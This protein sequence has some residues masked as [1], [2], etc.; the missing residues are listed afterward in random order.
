MKYVVFKFIGVEIPIIFP[1]D[2]LNHDNVKVLSDKFGNGKPV[3]AGKCDISSN[4]VRVWGDSFSLGIKSRK[5]DA[6]LIDKA[7]RGDKQ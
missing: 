7:I 4:S 6:A 2:V 3:S 5:V 1:G